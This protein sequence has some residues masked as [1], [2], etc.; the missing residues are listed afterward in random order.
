MKTIATSA[1]GA[2]SFG[3]EPAGVLAPAPVAVAAPPN[4]MNQLGT[5]YAT[6]RRRRN[7]KRYVDSAA[8]ECSASQ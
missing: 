6:K 7:G 4:A 2:V 1:G 3:G 8:D 5:V